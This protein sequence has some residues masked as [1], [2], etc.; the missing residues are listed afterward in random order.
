LPLCAPADC[1]LGKR[2][3][4][5]ER[6]TL[7]REAAEDNRITAIVWRIIAA[8]GE[9]VKTIEEPIP[10][11]HPRC[12]RRSARSA[13]PIRSG[14]HPAFMANCSN[15]APPDDLAWITQDYDFLP[16]H[17][18]PRYQTLI[19]REE[20]RLAAARAASAYTAGPIRRRRLCHTVSDSRA[21]LPWR[22][23]NGRRF[24]MPAKR[25]CRWQTIQELGLM[26]VA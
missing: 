17:D 5:L 18:H 25:D 15:S 9:L 14:E 10:N 16:L 20:A 7:E 19:A 23:R 12:Q 8:N 1:N 11:Q 2:L 3:E 6:E 21:L 24:E 13:A 4:K 22:E 26:L